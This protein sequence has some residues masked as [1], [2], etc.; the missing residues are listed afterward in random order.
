MGES[1]WGNPVGLVD[2]DGKRPLDA[3]IDEQEP[4]F[5]AAIYLLHRGAIDIDVDK[6]KGVSVDFGGAY[7]Q[8]HAAILLV[9]DDGEGYF[10][11]YAADPSL[12]AVSPSGTEGFLST[13]LGNDGM[14]ERINVMDFL[15][16]GKVKT[17]DILVQDTSSYNDKYTHGIYISITNGDGIAMFEAAENI[18]SNPGDYNL[19]I[20]NCNQVTQ[21]ILS[22]G[23]KNF[24]TMQFDLLDTRPNAV[25][26][27]RTY[28][29][30]R[31]KPEGWN[32]GSL[33]NLAAGILY[34]GDTWRNHMDGFLRFDRETRLDNG[35]IN[36]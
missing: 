9:Q 28:E 36:E 12:E 15:K 18:R 17:N 7:G 35:C 23:G 2:L 14:I 4:E 24:S 21:R 20:H 6:E 5:V 13:H 30:F 8:G 10:Y 33:E 31:D 11:S 25:Y 26:D 29:I 16:E 22:A 32:Y 34:D 3:F 27:R 19:Y 1:C